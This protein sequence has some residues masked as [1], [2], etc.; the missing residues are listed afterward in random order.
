VLLILL[1]NAVEAMRGSGRGGVAAR[2]DGELLHIEVSDEGPGIDAARAAEI[3]KPGYTTKPEGSGYGL[4]LAHRILAEARGSL[5]ARPGKT[6][7]AVL[8][9]T[10][11]IAIPAGRGER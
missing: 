1:R 10:L 2:R 11:P 5:E 3:F 8:D 4:F 6:R 9:L 7:G